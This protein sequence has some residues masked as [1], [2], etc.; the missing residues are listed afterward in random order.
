[1]SSTTVAAISGKIT[2]RIAFNGLRNRITAPMTASVG[3]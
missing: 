3:Q 1:M 2:A